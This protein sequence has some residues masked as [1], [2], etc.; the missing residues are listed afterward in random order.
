MRAIVPTVRT[1]HLVSQRAIA[2]LVALCV[3][4]AYANEV[5]TQDPVGIAV[6]GLTGSQILKE[7]DSILT[8]RISQLENA[9]NG[10][11]NNLTTRLSVLA[12][13]V[14]IDMKDVLDR[15]LAELQVAQRNALLAIKETSAEIS[16]A[17]AAAYKLEEIANIDVAG[18]LGPLVK[19]VFISSVRGLAV[20]Q[21]ESSHAISILATGLG[22]GQAGRTAQVKFFLN[23][24]VLTPN[25]VDLSNHNEGR[26]VFARNQFQRWFRDKEPTTLDLVAQL[27]VVDN[28]WF[29]WLSRPQYVN[30]HLFLT[31]Y[32]EYAGSATVTYKEPIYGWKFVERREEG[33]RTDDCGDRKCGGGGNNQDKTTTP[34]PK[35]ET[36]SPAPG[37]RKVANP[38]MRCGHPAWDLKGCE[39]TYDNSVV[40]SPNQDHVIA[41]WRVTGVWVTKYV[42]YDVLEW[43]KIDAKDRAIS[44]NLVYDKNVEFCLPTDVDY[45]V[46]S[47]RSVT[48]QVFQDTPGKSNGLLAYSG[49]FGCEGDGKRH[50]YKVIRPGS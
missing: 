48:G 17:T 4:I 40:L 9:G 26:Y 6:A 20:R 5:P 2:I 49:P 13:A 29:S 24:S 18:R 19:Q 38:K 14:R 44:L 22:P 32:P 36:S 21:W 50:S 11:V 39:Y 28:G 42:S 16:K 34:V 46:M 33:F 31:L 37:H 35:G 27:V 43:A 23:G 3:T 12:E 10:L 41:H 15:P 1:V 47:A 7:A 25:Q 45:Y 30:T 8:N